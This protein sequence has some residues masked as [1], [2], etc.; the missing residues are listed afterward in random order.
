VTRHTVA[1]TSLFLLLFAP[2][3][4]S[5]QFDPHALSD[6]QLRAIAYAA[7]PQL[8][9]GFYRED[10]RRASAYYVTV[11]RDGCQ[12]CEPCT[13]DHGQALAW[14]EASNRLNSDPGPVVAQRQT[15]RFFEFRRSRRSNPEYFLL[16]RVHKCSYLDR[17]GYA[18][19]TVYR[20]GV[21][22]A[23]GT[24]GMRP[25]TALRAQELAEYLWYIDLQILAGTKVLAIKTHDRGPYF[26]TVIT[27]LQLGRADWGLADGISLADYIYTVGKADGAVLFRMLPLRQVA[28]NLNP[29]PSAR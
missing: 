21:E 4:G 24:F 19:I 27:V 13:D 12:W 7:R 17:S 28:G 11:W 29:Y 6:A 23:L 22:S 3:A 9:P 14:S 16:E 25:V 20:P 26:E 1:L 10:R 15:E 2:V 5:E 18:G 8:P